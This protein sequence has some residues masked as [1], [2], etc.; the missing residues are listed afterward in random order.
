M[1]TEAI[2]EA[3]VQSEGTDLELET[4]EKMNVIGLKIDDLI[5]DRITEC[6]CFVADITFPNFNVYYEIGFAIGQRKPVLLT[7]CSNIENA[8]K[9]VD[10]IG[11]F[12]NIGY[13]LYENSID[14]LG[15]LSK[16]KQLSWMN[17]YEKIQNHTKP[18]FVIDLLS[19]S[20]FRQYIFE[21]I[22]DRSVEYRDFD[23]IDTGRFT[24]VTAISEIS[25]SAGVIIPLLRQDM[26]DAPIHNLRVA[27]AA[28]LSHG[29]GIDP[30][31]IQM[32]G[33]PAPL[34]YRDY[35]KNTK[36]RKETHAHVGEYCA[37]VL[38]RNQKMLRRDRP[39][40]RG[41]LEKIDIGKYAAENES[42]ELLDYFI[43]TS[44]YL[45]TERSNQ[46]LVVGR[47][48]S[49]KTAI[50]YKLR[51]KYEGDKDAIVVELR[52]ATHN[53]SELRHHL[54]GV[55]NQ[56]VF[57]HTISAFWQHIICLEVLLKIRER[58]LPLAK[59]DYELQRRIIEIEE[60]FSM[61]DDM[62]S[63]DFTSRL[64]TTIDQFVGHL[65]DPSSDVESISEFTNLIYE[66]QLPAAR[67]AILSFSDFASDIIVMFDDLDKGWPPQ[68]LENHDVMIIRHLVEAFK[69]IERDFRR[70]RQPFKSYLF[71]RSDVYDNLIDITSDRNKQNT[72]SV[73]WT[74]Y[75]QLERL[76]KQRVTS[77]FSDSEKQAA[78]DAFNVV[79]P[80][81]KF[82]AHYLVRASLY[83]PR[84]LIQ[85][86]EKVLACAINMGREA[87]GERDVNDALDQM[88]RYLISEL[89]YELRDISGIPHDI[90]YKFIGYPDI[91]T[92]GEIED[93]ASKAGLEIDS[94]KF[95]DLLLWYGFLGIAHSDHEKIFIFDRAYDFTRLLVERGRM[96]DDE[97]YCVNESFTRGLEF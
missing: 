84:F 58:V 5:R 37:S 62:V 49:G 32:D 60:E 66:K 9:G 52:P 97:L 36:G 29:F 10:E 16:W 1:I 91:I 2:R 40:P 71:L 51:S 56:G 11:I 21:E 53:L 50:L 24:S 61:N 13:V 93:I 75:P 67:N 27:F 14:L 68:Q 25:S 57:D 7:I 81:G 90:F 4:W 41:V 59:R 34:D 95:I 38:V 82:A 70:H 18:L 87:V 83:R 47:K 77:A 80:S 65:R 64:A 63:A 12:D 46:S 69:K 26:R 89:G 54:I 78:W 31:I 94:D 96:E 8:S 44:Q 6:D 45:Q 79:M 35:I 48:G 15:K 85:L 55:V 86:S 88:A 42:E 72:V 30:L 17:K 23:P 33:S 28:G 22:N 92:R 76:L 74:D 43:M 20:N 73:D 19:K 39:A 3:Q